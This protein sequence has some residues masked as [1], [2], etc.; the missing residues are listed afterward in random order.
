MT[1]LSD[2]KNRIKIAAQLRNRPIPELVA[3]SKTKPVERIL[4]LY[5]EGQRAFGENYVQEVVDK[6]EELILSGVVD[7]DFHFIGR[8]Q[9]NK[10][11]QLIPVVSTIHSVDSLRL[12][13]EIE[14]RALNLQ[15]SVSIYFQINID[16]EE[17]KGGFL[18]EALPALADYISV[19]T[20]GLVRPIG[21]MAIPNPELGSESAFQ[22][23][24]VLSVRYQS[25]FGSGLSMGMS[26]DFELAIRY[27]S[28]SIRVGSALFGAR[29]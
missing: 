3:V 4:E 27:G 7:I 29:E 12:F 21:L 6:H 10:V 2:L 23:M 26:E 28:T 1:V 19:N 18:P 8:L 16:R 15:K 11:K 22:E 17:S 25:V 5:R 14:R 13:Q 24:E 20:L 9:T